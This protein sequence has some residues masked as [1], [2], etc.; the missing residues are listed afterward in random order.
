M[1]VSNENANVN[2][3]FSISCKPFHLS[4]FYLLSGHRLFPSDA[5]ALMLQ[6][7]VCLLLFPSLNI[8][9]GNNSQVFWSFSCLHFTLIAKS[10]AAVARQGLAVALASPFSH[11]PLVSEVEGLPESLA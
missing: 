6:K 7:C 10:A 8:I 1:S 5:A 11:S 2:L 3:S 4:L 9:S